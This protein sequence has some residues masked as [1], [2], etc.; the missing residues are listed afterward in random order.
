MPHLNQSQRD[1]AGVFNR[2]IKVSK[3]ST[4][5]TTTAAQTLFTITG[6]K[7]FVRLFMA[8]VTTAH[9]GATQNI[10]TQTAPTLGTAVALSSDVDTNALEEGGT[11][12]VEGDGTAT[13]KANG[14]VVLSSTVSTGGGF[15]ASTGTITFTPSA[16]QAGAT[17]WEL[18]YWPID[19]G[20]AVA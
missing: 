10:K 1:Q 12:Y 15:I 20:A 16:T 14:G 18:W 2:G 9:A 7:I 19:D 13:V 8:T 5:Y 3:A 17:L 4:A 6:G 11:L